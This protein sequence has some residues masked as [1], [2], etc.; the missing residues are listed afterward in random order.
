MQLLFAISVL[1]LVAL[2]WAGFAIAR[3]ILR[4]RII[5]STSPVT[6]ATQQIQTLFPATRITH[7]PVIEATPVPV[8]D[9]HEIAARKTWSMP[10]ATTR[11]FVRRQPLPETQF[12]ESHFAESHFA[13]FF[14]G[15]RKSPQPVTQSST[16]AA[17]HGTAQRLD[18]QYY[19]EDL[20]DLSDPSYQPAPLRA[21]SGT[22]SATYRRF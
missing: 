18:R 11:N 20:G 8:Q 3:A 2:L 7:P 21:N 10:P 5:P 1:C 19:R 17:H 9:I 16:H 22:R 15:A 4:A 14:E 6:F 12:A 13:D